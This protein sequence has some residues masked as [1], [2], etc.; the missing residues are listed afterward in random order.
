MGDFR[1]GNLCVYGGE[2]DEFPCGQG[3]YSLHVLAEQCKRDAPITVT[4][5]AWTDLSIVLW[6]E[7]T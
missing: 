3:P 4:C 6:D 2:G 7:L 1:P 5:A